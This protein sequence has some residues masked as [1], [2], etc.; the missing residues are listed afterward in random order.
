MPQRAGGPRIARDNGRTTHRASA[1]QLHSVRLCMRHTLQLRSY[2]HKHV[3]SGSLIRECGCWKSQSIHQR[4]LLPA[5]GRRG[6]EVGIT[7]HKVTRRGRHTM[8]YATTGPYARRGKAADT[9]RYDKTVSA[10]TEK[11]HVS[12][13]RAEREGNRTFELKSRRRGIHTYALRNRCT[14]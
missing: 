13:G 4:E 11:R 7:Y 2:V 1:R 6:R 10:E 8:D 3:G 12:L 9:R 5:R 14:E